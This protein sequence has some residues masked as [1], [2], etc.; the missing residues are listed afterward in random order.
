MSVELLRKLGVYIDLDFLADDLCADICSQIDSGFKVDTPLYD[1]DANDNIHLPKLRQSRYSDVPEAT[2]SI[3]AD[4]VK[5][6]KPILEAHFAD[7]FHQR[8][9][10]A[11]FVLYEEGH[12]F[13]P[14]VDSQ[15][16]RKI[17]M[18]IYLNDEHSTA[19]SGGYSGGTLTLYGLFENPAF[20]N[21][22]ISLMGKRGMLIAYPSAT[23]H[24]VTPVTNGNR[25]AVITRFLDHRAE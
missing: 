10:P 21:K 16:H 6:L 8:A 25:Y 22:G 23:V 13:A 14:H 17:N 24:E 2:Q 7:R 18:S 5:R 12:F 11:K 3:I 4:R 20:R 15:L 9:E 19:M 1:V